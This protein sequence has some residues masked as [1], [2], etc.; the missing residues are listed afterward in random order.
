MG[1]DNRKELGN[2]VAAK[3]SVD[4]NLDRIKTDFCGMV[5]FEDMHMSGFVRLIHK[6]HEPES[7]LPQNRR[8]ASK[9]I[10][11][12]RRIKREKFA[13]NKWAPTEQSKR[14]TVHHMNILEIRAPALE[15]QPLCRPTKG[16]LGGL[17]LPPIPLDQFRMGR[18][19]HATVWKVAEASAS[20]PPRRREAHSLGIG[21]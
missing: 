14:R 15:G 21:F 1:F 13:Q 6:D 5:I 4:K 8:H 2:I 3:P 20:G 18:D 12:F 9:H 7:P 11:K 17:L 10:P 19:A 16:W